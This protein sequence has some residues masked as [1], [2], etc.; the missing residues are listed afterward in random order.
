MTE[1]IV[2]VNSIDYGIYSV[3]V[4]LTESG[5]LVIAQPTIEIFM[6]W[7]EKSYREKIASKSLKDFAGIGFH[8]VKI[9]LSGTFHYNAATNF[10]TTPAMIFGYA[11]ASLNWKGT[12]QDIVEV[13]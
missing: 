8:S 2:D 1:K 9:K 11:T 13:K 6:G 3:L 10:I 7:T 12:A 4:G 5:A